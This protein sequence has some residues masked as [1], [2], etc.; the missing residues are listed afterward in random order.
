MAFLE[1]EFPHVEKKDIYMGNMTFNSLTHGHKKF[2]ACNG[3]WDAI[4]HN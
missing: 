3:Y 4:V 1:L 2:L